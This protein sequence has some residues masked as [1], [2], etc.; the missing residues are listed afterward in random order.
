M[1]TG[2]LNQKRTF[3]L[4]LF[5]LSKDFYLFCAITVRAQVYDIFILNFSPSIYYLLCISNS[6]HTGL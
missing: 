1:G 5:F 4:F 6:K 3:P 2:F